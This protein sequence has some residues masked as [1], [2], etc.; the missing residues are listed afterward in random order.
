[1]SSIVNATEA[2]NEDLKKDSE[3]QLDENN[4]DTN[5]TN[6]NGSANNFTSDNINENN[7]QENEDEKDSKAYPFY[8]V[9]EAIYKFVN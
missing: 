4:N 3:N 6:D 9:R 2:V 5:I 8:R 1:M 7:D